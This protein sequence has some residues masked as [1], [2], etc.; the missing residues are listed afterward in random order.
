MGLGSLPHG[1]E[2][3]MPYINPKTLK[4][5]NNKW[6]WGESS[7]RFACEP[8][9]GKV[10]KAGEFFSFTK[11]GPIYRVTWVSANGNTARGTSLR[12]SLGRYI[13]T[14]RTFLIWRD[15]PCIMERET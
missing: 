3:L 11:K 7:V 13:D 5:L 2:R 6:A 9:P 12:S 10:S 4:D 14:H 1:R 8:I 15:E